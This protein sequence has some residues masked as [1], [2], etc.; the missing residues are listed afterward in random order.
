MKKYRQIIIESTLELRSIY[1]FVRKNRYIKRIKTFKL[2]VHSF[3]YR[4]QQ[5]MQTTIN[6]IVDDKL[7]SSI[8]LRAL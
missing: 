2:S 5:Q 7:G 6:C 1:T 3:H 8:K 4:N